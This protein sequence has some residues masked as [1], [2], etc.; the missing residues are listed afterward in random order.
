MIDEAKKEETQA[1]IAEATPE[2]PTEPEGNLMESVEKEVEAEET[3]KT[4]ETRGSRKTKKEERRKKSSK[5]KPTPSHWAKFTSCRQGNV[6]P[7]PCT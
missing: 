5:K 1:T 3:A 7:E 4:E 6:H 2:M